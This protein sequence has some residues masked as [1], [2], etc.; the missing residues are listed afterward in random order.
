MLRVGLAIAKLG[1]GLVLAVLLLGAVFDPT[2]LAGLGDGDPADTVHHPHGIGLPPDVAVARHLY[3][4]NTAIAAMQR[5]PVV[6]DPPWRPAIARD[7]VRPSSG[8]ITTLEDVRAGERLGTVLLLGRWDAAVLADVHAAR[9]LCESALRTPRL[10]TGTRLEVHA[11][12]RV[13]FRAVVG[14]HTTCQA[15]EVTAGVSDEA[16]AR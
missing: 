2:F 11:G 1:G 16:L 10:A 4:S 5:D 12:G 9:G 6:W 7:G 13:V 15:D 3:E 14:E 8:H